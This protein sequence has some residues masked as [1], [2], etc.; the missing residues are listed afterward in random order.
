VRAIQQLT[1]TCSRLIKK[2]LSGKFLFKLSVKL[3]DIVYFTIIMSGRNS[4]KESP[5]TIRNVVFIYLSAN[6]LGDRV[7][8]WCGCYS[9]RSHPFCVKFLDR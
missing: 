7:R 3:L 5:V 6:Q 1:L 4:R 9:S 2:R 8:W